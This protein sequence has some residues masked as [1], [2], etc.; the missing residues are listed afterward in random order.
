MDFLQNIDPT[1]L[2]IGGLACVGICVVGVVLSFIS[3]IFDVL[4]GLVEIIGQIAGGGP[5][6]WCGCLVIL[7][8]CGICAGIVAFLPS[9]NA[10]CQANY[11]N[12]CQLFGFG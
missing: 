3:G 10:S 7:G 5:V 4:I 2:A 9:I 6:A 11:T 8:G 12:F 1:I